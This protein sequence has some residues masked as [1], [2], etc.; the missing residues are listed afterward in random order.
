MCELWEHG[1][2]P[3]QLTGVRDK[4]HWSELIV[5][6]A[7]A[8][9]PLADEP[10]RDWMHD[11]GVFVSSL[12]DAEMQPFRDR[13]RS[14]LLA[15][16]ARPEMWEQLAPRDI[17]PERAYLDGVERSSVFLLILGTRYGVADQSGYAPAH[18]ENNRAKER[19]V[20]RLLFTKS[21]V[22][23][24]DRDGRLN[25]WLNSLYSELSGGTFAT[26]DELWSRIEG[27]LRE[28]AAE[29]QQFWIKLGR[30]VFPGNV[31]Q[32]RSRDGAT[33]RISARVRTP[34][35]R[36]ALLRLADRF[37]SSQA[38]DRVTWS[39]YSVKVSVSEVN[40][41]SAR[42]GEDC[43]D[44]ICDIPRDWSGG[45][46]WP[47]ADMG[48]GNGP[49]KE[50]TIELWAKWAFFGEAY[51]GRQR[52]DD[53]LMMF[54][55]PESPPLP[56]VLHDTNASGWLATGLCWLYLVE[57]VSRRYG[58][59]FESLQVGPAA[60]TSVPVQGRFRGKGWRDTEAIAVSGAVPLSL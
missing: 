14:G 7:I 25:D 57:E 27:R 2:T 47:F 13:V 21:D 41:N 58:G 31:E 45:A 48:Y 50:E 23:A 3:C 22:R 32:R 35:V 5:E 4:E 34:A 12:M 10:F 46:E 44:I 54:I 24:P 40:A 26:P 16:G 6:R 51:R 20:S 19:H 43:V 49:S 8:P 30:Y 28:I 60:A 9:I 1:S 36:N 38:P 17:P 59:E 18:K 29:E 53:M 15:W 11:R 39:H 37:G 55:Q 33:I 42:S 56:I 52:N